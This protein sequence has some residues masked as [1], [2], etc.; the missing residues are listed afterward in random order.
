GLAVLLAV[1]FRSVVDIWH[2][3]GSIGTPALLVPVF[4]AFTGRRR[5]PAGYGFVSIVVS[6]SVSMVWYL[7]QHFG[8]EQTYWLELEPIFP[9]LVCSV[10]VYVIFTRQSRQGTQSRQGLPSR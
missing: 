1:Y 6:G 9:G 8:R 10:V 2:A 4:V 3:F 7:S 5:L